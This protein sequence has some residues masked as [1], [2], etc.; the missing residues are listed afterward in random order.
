MKALG[1]PLDARLIGLAA[2]CFLAYGIVSGLL[3]QIGVV[4]GP[5]AGHFEVP[6]TAAA[7]RLGFIGT[8]VLLG[9]LASLVAF[10]LLSLRQAFLCCYATAAAA[11]VAGAFLDRFAALPAVFLVAG[12]AAGLGLCAAA[13]CLSLLFEARHRATALLITDLCFALT[14]TLMPLL[15]AALIG[16]GARWDT[17]YLVV[18]GLAGLVCLLALGIRFPPTAREASIT[19]ADDHPPL[20]AW[21]CGVGLFL[22]LLGQASLQ[23]W[24]PTWLEERFGA[25]LAAGAGAV[26]RYWTGMAIGQ[27]TLVVLL[28]FAPLRRWLLGTLLLS[29]FASS[30]VWLAS[31]ASLVAIAMLGLGLVNA[32]VLKLTIA[33]AAE[34]VRHPQRVVSAL[35]AA[36][37]LGTALGPFLSSSL[38]EVSTPLRALQLTTACQLGALLCIAPALRPRNLNS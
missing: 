19:I 4:S 10:E 24:L 2:A 15:A 26:S 28:R 8:G 32:G 18:A 17:S 30:A 25:D 9:T 1:V 34:L 23:L 13:V 29:V 38:V 14:G 20:A 7:A 27:A 22:F 33:G 21:C 12:A 6:L 3:T 31:D 35:L 11:L 36:S 16:G 37:A 5:M